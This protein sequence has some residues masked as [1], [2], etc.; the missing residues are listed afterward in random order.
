M[1]QTLDGYVDHQY[2]AP[3][4]LAPDP[5]LFG[6]FVEQTREKTGSV[7]G[8]RMYDVMRYWDEDH[9]DWDAQERDFATAWRSQPKWVV[10]RSL[11]SVGPNATLIGGD[12]EAVLRGLKTE[13][14]GDIEIGG[15]DL[16]D[17]TWR[18]ASL[19]LVLLT[20]IESISAPSCLAAASHSSPAPGRRSASWPAIVSA[21]TPS[22]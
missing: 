12:V 9:A 8:R 14:A 17:Q 15:P 10:S 3:D 4:P 13:L 6:H 19:N 20:S 21:R 16:A 7:Y 18:E 11:Q 2:F 1:N 22:D 5:Q